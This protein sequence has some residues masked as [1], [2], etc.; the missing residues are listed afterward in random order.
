MPD[1]GQFAQLDNFHFLRPW[2]L[3]MLLPALLVVLGLRFQESAT[4]KW[5]AI[6]APHLLQHLVVSPAG[7]SR[8]RPL[9]LLTVLMVVATL[10]LAGPSWRREP[11]PFTQDTAPLVLALDLSASMQVSDIQPSRLE[12]AQQKAADILAGRSGSRTA[13]LAYAGSAHM[14]LP[15]TD[16]P[17]AIELSLS[18]L[19]PELMPVPGKDAAQALALA[20]Q[21]L[22]TEE[23]P[24][25]IL[26]LTDGIDEASRPA[27]VEHGQNHRD[28]LAFLAV[29]TEQGGPIPAAEGGGPDGAAGLS[30]LDR[31]GLESL[32]SDSGGFVTL[33]TVDE[34]D[35]GRLERR[36]STHLTEVQQED[37]EG[38]WRD[39][40]YWLLF[41]VVLLALFWFRR[42]WT[43]QWETR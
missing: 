14:V 2:W 25:T 12:R 11:P 35:V 37:Q 3:L 33:V 5:R 23:T 41:P 18:S 31:A 29:A 22:S 38:R 20:Q 9:H 15:F 28:Q 4:W 34:T 1:L 40:G 21:L 17:D 24:G 42:G 32:A 30:R 39:D 6:I 10:A 27:F 8:I 7:R 26:F 19:G 43:I 36:I 16:D 13:L